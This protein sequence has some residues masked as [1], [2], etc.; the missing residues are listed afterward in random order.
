M[1]GKVEDGP[2]GEGRVMEMCRVVLAEVNTFVRSHQS[3][4]F[5]WVYFNI[6][7]LYVNYISVRLVLNNQKRLD[8]LDKNTGLCS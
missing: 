5:T 7:N 8:K 6:C 4:H 2:K 3:L 1:T